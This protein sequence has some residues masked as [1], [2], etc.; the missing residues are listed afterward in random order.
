MYTDPGGFLVLSDKQMKRFSKWERAQK[1][2]NIGYDYKDKP[3]TIAYQINGYE[4]E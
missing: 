4:V 3:F 2:Y 1:I